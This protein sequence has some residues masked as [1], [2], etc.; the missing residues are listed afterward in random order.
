MVC[1]Q[2]GENKKAVIM[3]TTALKN[4]CLFDSSHILCGEP[5]LDIVAVTKNRT[6]GK[7]NPNCVR[8]FGSLAIESVVE[9]KVSHEVHGLD[10]YTTARE[11]YCELWSPEHMGSLE[12]FLVRVESISGSLRHG[13]EGLIA[14]RSARVHYSHDLV[15]GTSYGNANFRWLP[16]HFGTDKDDIADLPWD[17]RGVKDA[18]HTGILA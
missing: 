14:L 13:R 15:P 3:Q 18:F 9:A 7:L 1:Q 16:K 5:Q 8:G 2:Y 10:Q 6:A 17:L 11:R 12:L 4:V